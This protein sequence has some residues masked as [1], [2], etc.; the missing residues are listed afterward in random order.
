M[1]VV[2]GKH[3]TGTAEVTAAALPESYGNPTPLPE[4]PASVIWNASV[5][6]KTGELV[7]R[8][9]YDYISRI[10]NNLNNDPN[11]TDKWRPLSM[12]GGAIINGN[13]TLDYVRCAQRFIEVTGVS[14]VTLP[15]AAS[16]SDGDEMIF[17]VSSSSLTLH[18]V[19]TDKISYDGDILAVD[20]VFQQGDIVHLRKYQTGWWVSGGTINRNDLDALGDKLS[21]D[22]TDAINTHEQSR[23]H[24]DASET[25]KGFVELATQAEVDTGTDGVRVLTPKTA[26]GRYSPKTH[27]HSDASETVKGLIELAT[28]TEVDTGTDDVRAI[29]PKKAALRY[30]PKGHGHVIGDVDGLQDAL[31][32]KSPTGH[33]H[34]DASETVKGLVELATQSEVDT[35]TDATRALTP[36]TAAGRY[37]PKSHGHPLTLNGDVSGS[38]TLDADGATITVTVA[39]DS[40]NH[41]IG[42]VDGLQSALDGKQP[43]DAT[44]T[45]MAGITTG[46]DKIIYFTGADVAT[47]T[48]LSAFART[49][50][51]DADAAAARATLGA[52]NIADVNQ[53]NG[54]S[55]VVN[56]IPKVDSSGI[57]NLGR[58]LDMNYTGE[59]GDYTVRQEIRNGAKGWEI[60]N[61]GYYNCQD[62]YIRSDKRDKCKI[63]KIT[64]ARAIV[65]LISGYYYHLHNGQFVTAGLIAQEIKETFPAAVEN[66]H[67]EAGEHRYVLVSSA[68]NGLLMACANEMD[69]DLCKVEDAY[70]DLV[71]RVEA[72]EEK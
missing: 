42:N 49:L 11:T 29:T 40:H 28:Q 24:P 19:G 66:S 71:K 38:G 26:A 55:N 44:L 12:R 5:K 4:K 63:K 56:K 43:L 3:H 2:D 53:A 48:T 8:G 69:A 25:A 16:L 22:I 30:S 67:N 7:T 27:T 64:N 35:G 10:D 72:L 34:P 39:D 6:Y 70:A 32:S 57:I 36:K 59:E 17:S 20:A 47:V 37:S 33:T 15:S 31:D 54:W 21:Q 1:K 13:V 68:I 52:V 60:Y 62:I 14:V 61:G 41:I 58:Y 50:M 45:A 46:A 9:Q 18:P 23:N 51:D 65:R